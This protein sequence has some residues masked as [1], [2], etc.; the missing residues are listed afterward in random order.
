ML[1]MILYIT[2]FQLS[3]QDRHGAV[4]CL[5]LTVKSCAVDDHLLVI[6]GYDQHQTEGQCLRW[7]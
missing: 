6:G 2:H 3:L 5:Q 7:L 1:N 4:A